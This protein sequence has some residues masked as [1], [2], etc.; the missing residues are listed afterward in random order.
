MQQAEI[1][2]AA[3]VRYVKDH[4]RGDI[5]D[6]LYSFIH[7]NCLDMA[8]VGG[9]F[10]NLRE[11]IYRAAFL[12]AFFRTTDE[13]VSS[14]SA[15]MISANPL[16]YLSE[17]AR[18]YHVLLLPESSLSSYLPIY[19]FCDF[20]NNTSFFNILSFNIRSVYIGINFFPCSESS[21]LMI[22]QSIYRLFGPSQV[23]A[24]LVEIEG[25]GGVYE[26]KH[27]SHYKTPKT[28]KC[29]SF[30]GFWRWCTIYNWHAGSRHLR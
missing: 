21:Y 6:S 10:K 2:H 17:Q 8:S 7:Q 11:K 3:Y 29:C 14:F 28:C 16:K 23:P 1:N 5:E 30:G 25:L 24:L 15:E 19:Y 26:T 18:F 20:P 22:W 27:S 4:I 9:S 12:Y 13:V